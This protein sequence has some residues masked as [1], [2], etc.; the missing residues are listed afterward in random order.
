MFI[1]RDHKIA[2][3]ELQLNT[4][5]KEIMQQIDPQ[6]AKVKD[7]KSNTLFVSVEDAMKELLEMGE[8]I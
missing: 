3:M 7:T 5:L 1:E 6:P 2:N 4:Q 8:K